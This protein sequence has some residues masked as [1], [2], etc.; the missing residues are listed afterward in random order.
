MKKILFILNLCILLSLK[1]Y[2]QAHPTQTHVT[3]NNNYQI[4][5]PVIL[6]QSIDVKKK[7]DNKICDTCKVPFAFSADHPDFSYVLVGTPHT[8][9][10]LY[11][12]LF[13]IKEH[14][15]G[16]EISNVQLTS[17]PTISVFLLPNYI[18]KDGKEIP[19]WRDFKGI[20][21]RY[22]E[23][24]VVL[25]NEKITDWTSLATEKQ[26]KDYAIQTTYE[27][28]GGSKVTNDWKGSVFVGTY[29]LKIDD[30]LKV[31][32][33]N[34]RTKKPEKGIFIQRLKDIPNNFVFLQLPKLDTRQRNSLQDF[35]NA[36][37]KT[38][39]AIE[40][41]STVYFEKEA[42]KIGVL[43]FKTEEYDILEY[44]FD[45]TL[46]WS[47]IRPGNFVGSS[48]GISLVLDQNISPGETK[49]LYLCYQHQRETVHKITIKA[50][51]EKQ[52][53][54][55]AKIAIASVL[56]LLLAIGLFYAYNRRQKKNLLRLHQKNKDIET[57]LSLLSGQLN[58]HFLFNSLHAIQ[59]TINSNNI[60]EANA[61][62]SNVA[63]FM[64]NIM[65]YGKKE[66]ISLKEELAIETDY[67]QLE[68][69]RRDFTFH[70]DVSSKLNTA[71]VDF[72]PLLLQPIMENSIRHA[73][74][75]DVKNPSLILTASSDQDHLTVTI[76]DNG[77]GWDTIAHPEGHGM[78]LVRKR[79]TL[80]NEKMKD[81]QIIMQVNSTPHE[82]TITIFTFK[83]WLS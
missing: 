32:V 13:E 50:K 39:D 75:G 7:I 17:N 67:L 62:I 26:S 51:P 76:K 53:V 10:R 54:P 6:Y 3:Q 29:D 52:E 15:R 30:S 8:P 45:D 59:G 37:I 44:S 77:T 56:L 34:I 69:K 57:R 74:T 27:K 18:V 21:Y 79:I 63:S 9:N 28:Q 68:Q 78:S 25:N 71:Q 58:P 16:P 80:L 38:E 22:C 41:D 81:M 55:W 1:S 46:H 61:Y 70:I 60:H 48:S 47:S 5:P 65:D 19:V 73:F 83:N 82:G 49:D 11:S 40:G 64:R 23:Y 2:Q 66:F 72:P 31:L 33:R 12:K 4:I 35:L 36:N 42:D 43:F 20:D 24:L 14:I